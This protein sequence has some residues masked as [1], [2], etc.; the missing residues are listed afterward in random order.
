MA[1]RGLSMED[2]SNYSST[3][4]KRS[5]D[6]TEESGPRIQTSSPSSQGT[7]RGI[8]TTTP[9]PAGQQE[10]E[11]IDDDEFDPDEPL[12]GLDWDE[13]EARYHQA[14]DER[15]N[16]ERKLLN[17]FTDLVKY[18]KVW[19]STTTHYE[20]DRSFARLKTRMAYTQHTEEEGE[21]KRQHYQKVVQALQSALDLLN[22]P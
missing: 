8:R 14:M 1:S 18:F 16:E 9:A 19:S 11:Q 17:D 4:R 12:P 15:N 13:L 2:E 21:Q 22:G 20:T 10:Q 5:H 7:Q 6:V 3:P